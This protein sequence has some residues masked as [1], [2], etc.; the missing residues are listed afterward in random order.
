MGDQ[1]AAAPAVEPPDVRPYAM[2]RRHRP[3]TGTAGILLFVC[4]FLPALEGCGTTTVLPLE[5]PP[6]LPPYLYG[7]AFASAAHARTQR[8]VIASVVIMR[9]LATL[10]TCA[11]FVVFLVAPAVGIVELAVGFVLL[12]AVGGRGYSERRLALTA[13]IIGAVCTFWFGL[14][15]T[16]A[17]ALIGVYL[18]LASS[19]GLLLGGSLWWNETARYPAHRIP[20]ASVMY[21]RA[22]EGF[23]GRA[24]RAV[25]RV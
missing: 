9:L 1:F 18:S 5:L 11:G 14:W 17:E 3:L 6:F 12:V 22:Y 7:L 21:H 16:T 19:V 24:V 25:R 2:H 23:V 4:M 20:A 13:M 15:A 8:S 10:V